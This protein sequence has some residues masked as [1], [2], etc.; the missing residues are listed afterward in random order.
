[1]IQ[2]PGTPPP[3]SKDMIWHTMSTQDVLS[4]WDSSETGLLETDA[5]QRLATEGP[6][7]LHEGKRIGPLQIL[8]GQFKSLIIWVLIIA[9]GISGVLGELSDAIAIFAIVILNAFIGFYQEFSAEK[10]IAALKRMTAPN[11]KV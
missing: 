7:E 10:S 1:M 3:R 11:A 9:G 5:A 4:H 8:L 6:N 2:P